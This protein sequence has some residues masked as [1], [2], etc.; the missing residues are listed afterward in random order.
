MMIL[1]HN[2]QCS[3][4]RQALQWLQ[5]NGFNPHIRLY[6]REPLSANE[7]QEIAQKLG[8]PSLRDMMRTQDA[9]YQEQNLAQAS[10]ETL[11]AALLAN[12]KLLERPILLTQHKAAIGRPL[13][14]IIALVQAA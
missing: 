11:Q 5:E 12:A 14:N 6:L 4:S 10:E 8:I 7:I 9:A 13:D 1:Y 3:K 2:P